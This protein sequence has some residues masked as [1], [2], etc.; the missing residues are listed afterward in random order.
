MTYLKAKQA[1]TNA[2]NQIQELR[3]KCA[4]HEKLIWQFEIKEISET[5]ML[6]IVM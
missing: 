1:L 6:I 4:A 5:V 3:R 2:T